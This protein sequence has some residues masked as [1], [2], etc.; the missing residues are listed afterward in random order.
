MK[1]T[2]GDI[3]TWLP[4]TIVQYNKMRFKHS[5]THHFYIQKSAMVSPLS[6]LVMHLLMAG[7]QSNL[8]NLSDNIRQLITTARQPITTQDSNVP[9]PQ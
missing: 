8:V 1:R 3:Q 7:I 5:S 2:T 9:F 4:S 6:H